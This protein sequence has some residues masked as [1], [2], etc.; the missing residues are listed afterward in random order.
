VTKQAAGT[1]NRYE[2][3]AR[4]ASGGMAELFLARAIA[5]GGI[6]RH[7][8]LK[9]VLPSLSA[10]P[11]FVSMFLD[12]AR[13]AAQLRHPNIAQLH[14]V[15]LIGE[16]FFYTME[17]VHG[18]TMESV[19]RRAN[20]LGHILPLGHVLTVAAGAAAGLHHAHTRVGPDRK[21]LD[22]VHRDVTLSNLMIGFE[23]VVKLLDFGVAKAAGRS[24]T[25][26]RIGVIKG[27]FA[28][29]SPEQSSGEHVDLRSD[30]FSLG[31][32]LHEM[33]TGRFLFLRDTELATM[34]AVIADEAP[35]PSRIRRDV[36]LS[37]DRVI[38][39]ALQKQPDKRFPTA[40]AMLD[41]IEVAAAG[42]GIPLSVHALGRYMHELFG[43]RPEPWLTMAGAY[44]EKSSVEITGRSLIATDS[45]P[46]LGAMIGSG[47][48]ALDFDQLVSTVK[49]IQQPA[50]PSTDSLSPTLVSKAPPDRPTKM[51]A[52]VVSSPTIPDDLF[53]G[54]ADPALDPSD[55]NYPRDTMLDDGV[56]GSPFAVPRAPV[57]PASTRPAPEHLPVLPVSPPVP[58]IPPVLTVAPTVSP[59]APRYA[60]PKP[61][62]WTTSPATRQLSIP[63]VMIGL[64]VIFVIGLVIGLFAC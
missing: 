31:I 46:G 17:Y 62:P 2:I 20:Q 48:D 15:G 4:L 54:A 16:A 44:E 57:V 7:V 18:E 3:L 26:T 6:E 14:D 35:P 29:L 36:P 13:L 5:A 25:T 42:A 40:A 37:I 58:A 63:R 53:A 27:K 61:P 10:D 1:S 45:D 49:R 51:A 52:P 50:P 23:G 30:I 24:S 60:P 8:V 39:T 28:Y 47:G 12:E 11:Q 22:I 55:P 64:L 56:F 21:P 19:M 32:C 9:K 33:L 38:A 34:A 41:A 59:P 43:D